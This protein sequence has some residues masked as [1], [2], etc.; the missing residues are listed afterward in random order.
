MPLD[1]NVCAERVCE[2][3]LLSAG[4]GE[5]DHVPGWVLVWGRDGKRRGVFSRTLLSVGVWECD[6]VSSRVLLPERERSDHVQGGGDVP[7][8]VCE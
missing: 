3:Q 2:W 4:I 5:P 1:W 8:G 6:L 7:G